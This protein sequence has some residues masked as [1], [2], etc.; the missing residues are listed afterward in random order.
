MEKRGQLWFVVQVILFCT[1]LL[2]PFV[3]RFEGSFWLRALGLAILISGVI[4]AVLGYRTLGSSHS[5]WT[6][7]I[8]GGHLV[9]TGIYHYTRHPIYTGWILG[10]LGGALLISSLLGIGVAIALF[11]FY[12]LKSREEEK[13]LNQKYVDYPAYQRQV[14]KFIPWVY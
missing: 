2:A 9:T 1:M 12:D 7:P 10:T 5:P 6:N 8:E 11:I 14:K 4:V 13:W 3:E